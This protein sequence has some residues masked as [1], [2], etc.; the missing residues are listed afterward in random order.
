[1]H[2]KSW[3]LLVATVMILRGGVFSMRLCYEDPPLRNRR[4][5]LMKELHVV[6]S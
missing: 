2:G 4:K 6:F 3:W 1:M 5:T